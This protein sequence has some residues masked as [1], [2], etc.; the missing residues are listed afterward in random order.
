M[1]GRAVRRPREPPAPCAGW[2][3]R[4]ARRRR[5]SCGSG[6]PACAAPTGTPGGAR[7]CARCRTCPVT[8]SPAG[9]AVGRGS[10]VAVGDRVTA[11]SSAGAA[12]RV[13]P[14]RRRAGLS[15]PVPSPASPT[16]VV[17]RPRRRACRRHQPRPPPRRRRLR[18]AAALGCR[19][20]TAYRALTRTAGCRRAS[21]SRCSAA[22]AWAC[23]RCSS[24]RPRLPDR[25]GR[26]P[27]RPRSSSPSRWALPRPVDPAADRR[28][29]RGPGPHRGRRPRRARAVGS[30]TIAGLGALAAPPWPPRAGRVV[31]GDD[32]TPA[33]PIDRVAGVGACRSTAR[34]A[35][36]RATIRRCST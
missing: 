24:P 22:A 6:P 32:A 20:A 2:R 25:R 16:G 12:L 8:S 31:F 33:V 28:G 5:R 30:S 1:G 13:V 3:S 7:P 34:T 15:R 17:R 4:P 14:R 27:A 9:R 36:R 21:G 18:A 10:G 35:S 29:G 26:P 23:R 19:F 11:P